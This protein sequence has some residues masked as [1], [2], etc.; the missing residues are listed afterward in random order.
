VLPADVERV[1]KKFLVVGANIQDDR[2]RGRGMQT[3]ASA[4]QRQFSDRNAHSASALVAKTEDPLAVAD[5]DSFDVI[6]TGMSDDSTDILLVRHAQKKSA[7]LAENVAEQLAAQPDCRRVDDRHHLFDVP[8]Q[9]CVEQDFIGVLQS[10]HE[11]VPL[12]VGM[13]ASKGFKPPLHL[14]I[15][16][17]YMRRQQPVQVE[18]VPLGFG[19]GRAF[20]EQRLVE[21]LVAAQ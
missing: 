15:K 8:G 6:V 12:H 11:R 19:E 13:K 21:Q 16:L 5:N 10:T 9:H 17:R 14:I 3:G 4:V 20:V 1:G 18:S 7:R 2:Q